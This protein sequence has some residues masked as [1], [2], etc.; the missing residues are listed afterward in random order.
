MLGRISASERPGKDS[1]D[2]SQG[3]TCVIQFRYDDFG[4]TRADLQRTVTIYH[5]PA[6][7]AL[8]TYSTDNV[9]VAAHLGVGYGVTSSSSF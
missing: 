1:E 2:I 8:I 6:V 9:P 3:H 7:S 5:P 4:Q